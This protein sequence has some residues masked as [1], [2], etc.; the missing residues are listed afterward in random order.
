MISAIDSNSPVV[1]SAHLGIAETFPIV[2][3]AD[4]SILASNSSSFT[5]TLGFGLNLSLENSTGS[6]QYMNFSKRLAFS[7]YVSMEASLQYIQGTDVMLADGMILQLYRSLPPS[8]AGELP[9][10]VSGSSGVQNVSAHIFGIESPSAYASATGPVSV[11]F[12]PHNLSIIDL[13]LNSL[14]SINGDITDV[15]GISLSGLNYSLSSPYMSSIDLY[16][17]RA[18]NGTSLNSSHIESLVKWNITGTSLDVTRYGDS[19]SIVQT[20]A[21]MNLYSLAITSF[22]L[23]AQI[24]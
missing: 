12:N 5:Y 6:H 13:A 24:S 14:T 8:V 23:K 3:A 17:Y 16:L 2:P 18:Y 10:T 1:W 7:G 19:L 21:S 9:L 11:S 4:T 22:Q 20:G 15:K